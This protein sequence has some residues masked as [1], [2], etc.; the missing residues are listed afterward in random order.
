[1]NLERY[2]GEI[3]TALRSPGLFLT[4]GSPR[5]NTTAITWGAFGMLWSRPIA[6]VPVRSRRFTYDLIEESGVFTI[7]VPRKDLIKELSAAGVLSGR[8]HDK[9][10]KLHLHPAKARKVDTYIV[11]DC[12]LHLECRVIYKDPVD[13]DIMNKAVH[14]EMYSALPL[15]SMFYGEI[16]DLYET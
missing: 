14:S 1:M 7:S 2:I 3:Y 16:V 6:V 10:T 12:G 13:P 11:A 15:H 5:A 4:S 9:F 8:D